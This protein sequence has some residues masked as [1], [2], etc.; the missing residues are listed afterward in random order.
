MGATSHIS[1]PPGKSP[2][3]ETHELVLNAAFEVEEDGPAAGIANQ[4]R[5]QTAVQALHGLIARK[6]GAQDAQGANV[7]GRFAAVDWANVSTAF[8]E[9]RSGEA[10]F[11][12]GS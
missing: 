2:A 3:V 11:E 12:G 9:S 8:L 10:D 7:G 4:V 5:G 1:A 6:E